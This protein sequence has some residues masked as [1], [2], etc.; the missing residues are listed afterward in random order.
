[1]FAFFNASAGPL[2][3]VFGDVA[4]AIGS[5]FVVGGFVGGLSGGVLGRPV[6]ETERKALVGSYGGGAIALL[7]LVID[8]VVKRFV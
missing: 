1:V 6:R 2:T 7:A 3:T 5:G 4:T 8:I